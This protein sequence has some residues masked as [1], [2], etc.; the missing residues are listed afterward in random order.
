[1]NGTGPY[2][3]DSWTPGEEIVLVRN[4]DYWRTEP[5][6]E[7][8][9]TGP[10]RI[11]RVIIKTIT[12]WG[13]RLAMMEAGDA[14]YSSVDLVNLPQA[15]ALV[16][17][18]CDYNPETNDHDCAP[19][20]TPEKP[21]KVYKNAPGVLATSAMFNFA[22]NVE[23][24]NNLIGS[25]KLD[26][27]GI[28]PNFFTD[29]H[30]RKA[31]N[32]CFDWDTFI[33]EAMYG[34]AVQQVGVLIPGSVGYDPN[35]KKYNFDLEK[36]KSEIEAAWNGEVA[37]N[38]FRF[39]VAYNSGNMMRQTVAQIFQSNWQQVDP[40]YVVEVL[41]V[42]WP[43]F[44]GLQKQKRLPLFISGWQEDIH[45]SHN[46]VQPFLVGDYANRQNI[47]ANIKAKYLE[48]VTAGVS[49]ADPAKRAEIYKKIQDM[50]Y[51]D[52]LAVRIFVPTSPFYMQRW[53]KDYYLNPM[54]SEELYFYSLVEE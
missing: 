46:W 22:I 30:V 26:G 36:C 5:A 25:G 33:Q 17:E 18:I 34:Q 54:Y 37:K 42:P 29:I 24:G 21:L 47:P 53:I 40:K 7:G 49:E 31:F 52:V 23:G 50:D 10:A 45:D 9:P 32:Y 3:F 51:E 43:T 15:D 19:S 20:D 16:G 4:D 2:K 1:M 8:A 39:Q 6:W 27:N 44:N 14:D 11:G 38:G 35:G 41:A 28:P 48:L 13:T 12:E